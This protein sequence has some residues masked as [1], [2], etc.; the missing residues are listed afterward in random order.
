MEPNDPI[1][2]E[3]LKDA[4]LQAL[5]NT[6]LRDALQK[7]M[8]N[9]GVDLGR[10]A[11]GEGSV[12]DAE[13]AEALSKAIMSKDAL[14][15]IFSAGGDPEVYQQEVNTSYSGSKVALYEGRLIAGPVKHPLTGEIMPVQKT[16]FDDILAAV[17]TGDA[18]TGIAG[19]D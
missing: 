14:A 15:D 10:K 8:V 11:G 7:V 2:G 18:L 19:G 16:V 4:L 6:E 12:S 9:A 5:N 1:T 13:L 3:E 17:G